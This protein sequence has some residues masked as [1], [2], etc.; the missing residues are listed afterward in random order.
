MMIEERFNTCNGW[1]RR[2][3]AAEAITNDSI[4]YIKSMT[5][6]QVD[7]LLAALSKVPPTPSELDD[8]KEDY[9]LNYT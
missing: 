8:W 4:S 1:E 3:D 5:Q 9:L 7:D 6:Q 2:L